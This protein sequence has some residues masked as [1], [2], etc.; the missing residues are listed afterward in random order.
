MHCPSE[1]PALDQDTKVPILG[2]ADD[3]MLLANNPAGLQKLIDVAATFCDM[4]GMIICTVKTKVVVFMLQSMPPVPWYCKGQFL[5]QVQ[6]FKYLGLMFSA[7]GGHA[8]NF[9]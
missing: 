8:G 1:G 6:E 9:P 3:F 2:Y 7:Q 4:V 5:Q